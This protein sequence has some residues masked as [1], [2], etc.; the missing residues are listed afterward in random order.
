MMRD[1]AGAPIKPKSAFCTLKPLGCDPQRIKG[2]S[3]KSLVSHYE[4]NYDAKA[5]AAEVKAVYDKIAEIS[6]AKPCPTKSFPGS[7]ASSN[8]TTAAPLDAALGVKGQP[9][10]GTF[11]IVI[12]RTAAMN[13]VPVAK[14]RTMRTEGINIV[15]IHQHMSHDQPRYLFLHHW[16]K[17]KGFDLAQSLKRQLD[18]QAAVKS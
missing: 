14:L 11:K 10:Q 2:M 18:A 6:A 3:E 7:I 17:G 13:G 8:S 15:A 9:S 12:V 16:G 4:N 1:E 5:L